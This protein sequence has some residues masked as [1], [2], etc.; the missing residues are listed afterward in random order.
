MVLTSVR[1]A[2]VMSYRVVTLL[3]SLSREAQA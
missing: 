2:E 3:T 1:V